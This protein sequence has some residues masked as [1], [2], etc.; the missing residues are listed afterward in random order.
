MGAY[1]KE[2]TE[3]AICFFASRHK[4]KTG[5]YLFQTSLYK[6]LALFEIEFL[7]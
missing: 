5:K 2:K 3:N 6:D 1:Q 7:K 4:E